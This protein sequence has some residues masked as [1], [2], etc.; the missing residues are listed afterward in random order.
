MSDMSDIGPPIRPENVVMHKANGDH[1]PLELMYEGIVV[2]QDS[3]TRCHVW[4]CV[5]SFDPE[6][7]DSITIGMMPG[8]TGIH[9]NDPEKLS[10]GFLKKK[11][12]GND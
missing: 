4:S 8:R 2:E 6:A 3:G 11:E 9:F 1:I 10:G 12:E 5:T 7:G